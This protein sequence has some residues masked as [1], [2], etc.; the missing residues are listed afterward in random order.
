M[1]LFHSV[2]LF[3]VLAILFT[4]FTFTL[5]VDQLRCIYRNVSAIDEFKGIKP[6]RK[7]FKQSLT[8]VFGCPPSLKWWVL[9]H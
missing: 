4:L 6:H 8:A 7:P 5:L 9:F 2:Q 1:R 3:Y